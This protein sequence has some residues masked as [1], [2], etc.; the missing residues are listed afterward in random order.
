MIIK[1]R[2]NGL[3]AIIDNVSKVKY[4][5]KDYVNT[6]HEYDSNEIL[7]SGEETKWKK[8]AEQMIMHLALNEYNEA[9]ENVVFD[10]TLSTSVTCNSN[11]SIAFYN[12]KDD[13][14]QC[15]VFNSSGFLLS[16]NGIT[17]ERIG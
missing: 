16:D 1:Y 8:K 17:I 6:V 15:I 14:R 4:L 9:P 2:V 13:L 11:L 5:K 10:E 7:S 12:D 3:W